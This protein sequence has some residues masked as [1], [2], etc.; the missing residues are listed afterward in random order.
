METISQL[1]N[2]SLTELLKETPFSYSSFMRWKARFKMGMP[3]IK[4]PGP[5]KVENIDLENLEQDIKNLKHCRKRTH[6]TVV[7]YQQYKEQ[8]S[9]REFNTMVWE[10]RNA[11]KRQQAA[12]MYRILWHHPDL[13]WAIDGSD[14][15]PKALLS[16]LSICNVQDLCSK[17]KFPP[18]A[19]SSIACGESLSGHL[20]RLFTKFG[21]PLFFKRDNQG[22]LNHCAVNDTLEEF[23]VIPVNSPT[24]YAQYNG[25]IEHTQGEFKGYLRKWFWKAETDN[26]MQILSEI[27]AHDLNH[28]P[29]RSLKGRNSCSVYFGSRRIKFDRRK[30][31]EVFLWIKQLTLDLMDKLGDNKMYETSWRIA[32]RTWLHKNHLITVSKASKV[33]PYYS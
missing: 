21:V 3:A 14:F 28:M 23:M 32:A 24:Y 10:A 1:F 5:K 2:I 17:Y 30:R 22:N 7:L 18:I 12:D 11:Y 9:R 33:L 31:K 27:G 4:R 6:K 13:A 15:T 20:A 8:V 19:D 25:S 16:K 26:E 29:R